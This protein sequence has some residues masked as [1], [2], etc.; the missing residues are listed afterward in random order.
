MESLYFYLI[1]FEFC[2][3]EFD[4]LNYSSDFVILLIRLDEI[5]QVAVI[6]MHF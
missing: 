2:S 1:N 4:W 5:K 3:A 6:L